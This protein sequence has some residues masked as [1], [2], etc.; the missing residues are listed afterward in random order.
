MAFCANCGNRVE[1]GVKFCSFCGA[2]ID[3]S[4]IQNSTPETAFQQINEHSYQRKTVYDG[5]I[6]KCPHCGAPL[7]SFVKNCPD[8]GYE[9]RSSADASSVHSFGVCYANATNNA[10]KID[11]IRT[12]VIPNTKEDILEFVFLAHSNIDTSS[13]FKDDIVAD[14]VSQQDITDAWM[15][16]LEQAYQKAN[17]LL[18]DDPYL[19]KINKLYLDKKKALDSA[20][21][22][23][24]SKKRACKFFGKKGNIIFLAVFITVIIIVGIPLISAIV[25]SVGKQNND[26]ESPRKMTA[27]DYYGTWKACGITLS[28]GEYYSVEDL[29]KK[30]NYSLSDCYIVFKA[31]NVHFHL[32]DEN[33]GDYKWKVTEKGIAFAND[34]YPLVLENGKLTM[35]SEDNTMTLYFEKK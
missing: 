31:E 23:S 17:I 9:I 30:G 7:A 20:R 11:L 32:N 3:S 12:F 26:P 24:R 22:K 5:E 6:H 1:D 19:D 14:G 8:C 33:Q 13:Y 10:H 18:S 35:E 34:E 15:V 29:E 2:K 16:K 4:Y 21:A 27:S 28:N 25:Q